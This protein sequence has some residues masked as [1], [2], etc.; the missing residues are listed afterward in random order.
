MRKNLERHPAYQKV[1]PDKTDVY[2]PSEDT[3]TLA[4]VLRSYRG[5]RCLEI[6]FGGGAVLQSLVPRFELVVGTDVL[7]VA[8]AVSAKGEAEVVLV[9]RASCFRGGTFDLVAFNP[10]YLPSERIEDRA[11]D[12]GKGGLEVPFIFLEEALRVLKQD[13]AVVLLLS[14]EA[15]LDEFRQLCEEKGLR[16]QEKGRTGLFF[17]NLFV[18]EVRRA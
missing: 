16:V 18:F 3:A 2:P 10:P 17:E 8:Q 1:T 15:D 12:G 6:G 9:D 13:G 11:V 14:D 4:R 5:G 7:S